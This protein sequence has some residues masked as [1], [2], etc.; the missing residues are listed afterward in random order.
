MKIV[1]FGDS[2]TRGS[3]GASFFDILQKKLPGHTLI[4][5][6]KGG[7]KAFT[8]YQRVKKMVWKEQIDLSF[9]WVGVNDLIFN[10]IDWSAPF[11]ENSLRQP[12]DEVIPFFRKYF[13]YLLEHLSNLSRKVFTVPPLFIGEDLESIWHEKLEELAEN[14]KEVTGLY[15]NAEYL[16]LRAYFIFKLKQ[17]EDL[18]LPAKDKRARQLRKGRDMLCPNELRFTIDGV[19]LNDVSARI[20]ANVFFE[21]IKEF[22]AKEQ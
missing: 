14:I 22:S 16:D 1:F 18:V 4:N 2:I 17:K 3:P 6:G 8:L 20:V 12:W 11:S 7:E 21:K 10:V 19:H 9:L 13:G 5:Q 15:K